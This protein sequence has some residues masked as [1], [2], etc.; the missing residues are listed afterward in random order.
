MENLFKLPKIPFAMVKP[1]SERTVKKIEKM[2]AEGYQFT[3]IAKRLHV[4]YNSVYFHTALR[5]RGYETSGAYRDFLAKQRGYES[6]SAYC[7]GLMKQHAKKPEYKTFAYVIRE[8]LKHIEKSMSWLGQEIGS[9][10]G[11]VTAYTRARSKPKEPRLRQI[12]NVLQIEYESLD[13]VIHAKIIAD[14][15]GDAELSWILIRPA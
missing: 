12:C 6:H 5:E 2:V 14:S 1:L 15:G 9:S 3:Q 10:A 4:S 7:L 8:R 13:A 11:L